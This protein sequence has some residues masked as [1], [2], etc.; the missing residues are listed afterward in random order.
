MKLPVKVAI[1]FLFTVALIFIIVNMFGVS[2]VEK[3]LNEEI[4]AEYSRHAE[5]IADEYS[6]YHYDSSVSA[7][8]INRQLKV[9]DEIIDARIWICNGRGT[10]AADTR[11]RILLDT[12]KAAPGMLGRDYSENVM[13]PGVFEEPQMVFVSP[14]IY[15]YKVKGYV[16]V[17]VPMS[18]ARKGAEE[19]MNVV[20]VGL[21]IFSG[22]LFLAFLYIYLVAVYPTRKIR[23]AAMEYARGNYTYPMN[24]SSHD[25]IRDLADTISYMVGEVK[26][27]DDNQKK[28]IANISHD[29]RSPLTSIKGY[30]EAMKDGT[31]PY[32]MQ[33]K[34]LD[35]ILFETER[36]T[37]LTTNLLDLTKMDNNGIMLDIS[38]FDINQVIQNVASAFE[39][40]CRQKKIVM[41]LEFAAMET[42][43][44]ADMGRIQQVLYNLTDNAIKF[45]EQGSRVEIE[46]EEKGDKVLIRVRDFGSGIP[47][48]S[49][50]KIWDRFYKADS[51]RGKDKKGTGLG[52]SIV[53]EIITA[54]GENISVIS[55]EG[56]GTEFTFSLSMSEEE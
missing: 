18:K 8:E 24:V 19:Y 11:G 52:L 5:R 42:Y 44:D 13:I 55:T 26:Q 39:G 41:G 20:N 10:V 25:E 36:L 31:I 4:R 30:A 17:F 2:S 37:K 22:V 1:C 15:E 34:Y 47:K 54:H 21:L 35:I 29:F 46:T 3:T 50:K 28:F 23:A 51:S 27:A 40:I 48:E 32:E 56:V 7:T 43:V 6:E 14:V 33:G 45:S 16:C 38:S 12:E 49:I 9:T 53:K